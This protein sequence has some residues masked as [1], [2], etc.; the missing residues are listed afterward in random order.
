[1]DERFPAI[2]ACAAILLSTAA[3][4]FLLVFS[5]CSGQNSDDIKQGANADTIIPG[6]DPTFETALF[7]SGT[8][9]NSVDV[10]NMTKDAVRTLLSPK[11]ERAK[12]EYHI[13][14][15][16]QQ[17]DSSICIINGTDL[18]LKDDLEAVM[19]KALECGAGQYTTA[20]EPVDDIKLRNSI[21]SVAKIA[22]KT[23]VPAQILT[24][25]AAGCSELPVLKKNA[26]FCLTAP[27]NG[28]QIDRDAAV[29]Q[30]CS[31]E[32]RFSLPLHTV[33]CTDKIPK[34]P[35][36]RAS[37]STSFAAGSLCSE[38]RVH[39]ITKGALLIDGSI[40]PAGQTFS[41]NDSLGVRSRENG[42]LPATA[43]A[44]GGAETRQ[45]Y[46]GGICQIS[47]TLYNAVLRSDL[48]IIA[49]SGHT[50][51]VRYIGGG[52][53]AALSGKDKDF[54]FR[55]NT[56]SDIYV[57]MW[58]DESQKTLCCEIYGCPFPSDFDR[59]DTV[60]ELTSSTPPSEPQFVLDSALEPGECVLKRKAIAG[61]TY[62]SY[63]VYSL[64]GE[65]IR[66]VPIDKTEYPMHPALYAVGQGKS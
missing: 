18:T 19:S 48:E 26:R 60:S 51:K 36:L 58:V 50:R 52:L 29:K 20:I 6:D 12:S 49:R 55:N 10:S 37:F 15:E 25:S 45:E 16:F 64:N 63:R 61:S 41:C 33:L 57:F 46:G 5:C 59:V 22:E 35:E 17:N 23:P 43:F 7:S 1:M 31:G 56:D 8:Y 54:V 28:C 32:T 13:E 53:D 3:L 42:W 65:I 9:I 38:N 39:N 30:I 4:L 47:T 14:I 24:H 66:R 2:K 62:Q 11:L 44:N 27:V 40:V 21:D 34:M